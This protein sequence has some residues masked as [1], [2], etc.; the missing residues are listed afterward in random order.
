MP[1]TLFQFLIGKVKRQIQTAAGMAAQA[2]QFL[3]GKVK[4]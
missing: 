1:G 2:F 3:I 4:S